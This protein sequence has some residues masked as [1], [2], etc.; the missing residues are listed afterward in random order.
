MNCFR[1]DRTKCRFSNVLI[2]DH[3]RTYRV[4]KTEF[5]T[6]E[7]VKLNMYKNERS[8][9]CQFRSGVLPRRIE[10]GRYIGETLNQRLCRFCN[11]DAVEDEKHFLFECA[12]Y[13]NLRTTYSADI[14]I[15]D[16]SGT[17]DDKLVYAMTNHPRMLAKF[18]VHAYLLRR[19]YMYK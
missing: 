6:E 14:F 9:M 2:I 12:L 15:L 17:L 10:T 3:T 8:I 18:L 19:K 11:T 4:F 1:G 7:Y 16:H 13:N 5:K